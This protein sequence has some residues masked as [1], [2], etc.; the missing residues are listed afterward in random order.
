M[1]TSRLHATTWVLLQAAA[2]LT[3]RSLTHVMLTSVL[4]LVEGRCTIIDGK[5]AEPGC[6]DKWRRQQHV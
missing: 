2:P 5:A 1:Q 4:G 6:S 3:C